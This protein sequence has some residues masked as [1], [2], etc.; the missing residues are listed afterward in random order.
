MFLIFLIWNYIDCAK[1]SSSFLKEDNWGSPVFPVDQY[2]GKPLHELTKDCD[3]GWQKFSEKMDGATMNLYNSSEDW[4][5]YHGYDLVPENNMSYHR[6]E[7]WNLDRATYGSNIKG[8]RCNVTASDGTYWTF[9][10]IGPIRSVGNYDWWQFAW[11][12]PFKTNEILRNNPEGFFILNYF[13][14]AVFENGRTLGYPPIHIHHVHATPSLINYYRINRFKCFTG[15]DEHCSLTVNTLFEQHGDYQCR[16]K[17][18]GVGCL[19][20]NFPKGYA[21]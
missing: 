21:R 11:N 6:F 18:G 20:E 19:L 15:I 1:P 8:G 3:W 9:E 5:K 16:E 4:M 2:V 10:R 13:S 17:D 7:W 12:D 14:G